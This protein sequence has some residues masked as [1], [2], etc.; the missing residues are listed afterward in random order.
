VHDFR[1]RRELADRERVTKSIAGDLAVDI[2]GLLLLWNETRQVYDRDPRQTVLRPDLESRLRLFY[3]SCHP[4]LYLHHDVATRI[5][6]CYMRM[7]VAYDSLRLAGR[8]VSQTALAVPEHQRDLGHLADGLSGEA[9]RSGCAAAEELAAI[10]EQLEAT[11]HDCY[12]SGLSP[13]RH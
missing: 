11:P 3:C 8:F 1:K 7:K 5:V 9:V 13:R 2:R 10:A 12:P 4:L 6:A